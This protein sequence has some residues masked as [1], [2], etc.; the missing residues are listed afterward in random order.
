[1]YKRQVLYVPVRDEL[2]DAARDIDEDALRALRDKAL[3]R[4]GLLSD[5]MELLCLLYTSRCV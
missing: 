2:P 1:M 5:D 3:R 4:S